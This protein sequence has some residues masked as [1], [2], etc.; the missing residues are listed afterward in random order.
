[1]LRKL[2]RRD[3]SG[4]APTGGFAI[5]AHIKRGCGETAIR[6]LNDIDFILDSFD[7]R[8]LWFCI[9]W[10]L[11]GGVASPRSEG[12]CE[13]RTDVRRTAQ[14]TTAFLKVWQKIFCCGMFIRMIL[15]ARLCCSA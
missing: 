6:P 12:D 3:V 14:A 4:W 8:S 2:T 7:N 10:S 9:R 1:M 15:A 13:M 5:E 11:G